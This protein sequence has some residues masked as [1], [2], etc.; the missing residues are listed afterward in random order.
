[1]AQ[2]D[3]PSAAL[4]IGISPAARRNFRI[5]MAAVATW[6][7]AVSMI[8]GS[9]TGILAKKAF[10]DTPDWIIATLAAAPAFSNMSSV[11]WA[12]MA[13][14]QK[15]RRNL[16]A[17]QISVLIL[18]AIIACLPRSTTGMYLFAFAAASAQ[19]FM[20][21][22]TTLR[23]VLWRANYQR[24][25]RSGI[26]G[27]LITIQTI[28]ISLTS[29]GLGR[30]MDHDPDFFHIAYG[31]AVFLGSIGVWFFS[32]IRV[33]RPFLIEPVAL[34]SRS[35]GGF[36]LGGLIG[37]WAQTIGGMIDV[38]R[39]DIAY[40]AYMVCMF[41]LGISNLALSGPLV[42]VVDEQFNLGYVPSILLLHSLP[43]ALIPITIPLWSR[44]MRRWHIIRFR[45]VHAWVF[46]AAQLLIFWGVAGD[47]LWALGV[48][49]ALRGV[50]FGGGALA[51]NL[52]HNDFA[53]TRDSHTYMTIHVTLTGI[54]GLIGGYGGMLLY[55][56]Y[57]WNGVHYPLL[58]EYAF[59]FWAAFATLGSLGF[60][61]LNF[62]LGHLTR[63][64]PVER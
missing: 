47:S 15:T 45:A 37:E 35:Q 9:V 61:Y 12:R 27:R 30:M 49:L 7:F 11:I 58:G 13:R 14:G 23:A 24:H 57:T 44:L 41:V 5:E 39:R 51:W 54:R 28:I 38:M 33:R 32:R 43:L 22:V 36:S 2:I 60:V 29:L 21:G 56:G 31:A 53:S 48:G 55:A 63:E 6:P 17:L 62:R 16:N 8:E 50:G 18:I 46:V 1:M 42:K 52:G 40:R 26:T 3:R 4:P 34:S 20:T 10:T 59:L 19:F 25:E 64:R